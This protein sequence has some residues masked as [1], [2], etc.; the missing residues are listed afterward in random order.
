MDGRTTVRL[1]ERLKLKHRRSRW[2][3]AVV[4]IT[5]GFLTMGYAAYLQIMSPRLTLVSYTSHWYVSDEIEFKV[6]VENSGFVS[7]SATLI[8]EARFPGDAS[9]YSGGMEFRLNASETTM[10][11]VLVKVPSTYFSGEGGTADCHLTRIEN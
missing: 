2:L 7:A 4:L 5:A 6:F 8:C 9:V 1:R 11:T 10:L 3:L